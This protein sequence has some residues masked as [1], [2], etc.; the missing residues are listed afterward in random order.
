MR[1]LAS[2]QKV[3]N[4][5][6]IEGA[7]KIQLCNVLGWQVIIAKADGFKEGDLCIYCEVDSILPA[8]PEF[9]FLKDKKYRIKTIKLKGE[10]SQGICFPLNIISSLSN[11]SPYKL[12]EGDDVTELLGIK[13]YDLQA[14]IEQKLMEEQSKIYKNRIDKF[15]KKYSWYRKLTFKPQR[16]PLPKF[17]KKTDEDRIQLFPNICEEHK[18]T[19]FVVTEKLDGCSASYFI[20]K[21]LRKWQFWKK[22]ILGVCSRNFQLLIPDDSVYWK[23][24]RLMYIKKIL[25]KHAC[26]TGQYL[27][28]QGE[29]IGPKVQGNK[30]KLSENQFHIFNIF[31]IKTQTLFQNNAREIWQQ[32]HKLQGVPTIN[33]NFTLK[34]SVKEMVKYSQGKSQLNPE[35]EREGIVI[36]N[37]SKNISFKVINPQFLMQYDTE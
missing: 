14:T 7:D 31:D 30:Y 36:R 19:K 18:N 28:I 21:N 15:L 22:Y 25:I 4:I 26:D 20:V 16:Y 9:E 27:G 5:R 35:I 12:Q 23:I 37:Y 33:Q 2:I 10:Y 13:K 24:A 6:P 11:A 32:E 34:D 8:R 3:Y 1:K 29:I 17:I